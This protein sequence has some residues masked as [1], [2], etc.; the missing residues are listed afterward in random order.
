MEVL[1]IGID[2]SPILPPTIVITM[3]FLMMKVMDCL[4]VME[5]VEICLL[6]PATLFSRNRGVYRSGVQSVDDDRGL[7]RSQDNSHFSY[8]NF[9]AIVD[10]DGRGEY[11]SQTSHASSHNPGFCGRLSSFSFYSCPV[12]NNVHGY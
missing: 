2:I 3:V 5:D 1:N 12:E 7:Y 6:I 10:F 8:R 4:R 9:V 11:R